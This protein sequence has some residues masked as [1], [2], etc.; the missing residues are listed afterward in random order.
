MASE[1]LRSLLGKCRTTGPIL[2]T[3]E[4]KALE[5]GSRNMC[6]NMP[7]PSFLHTQVGQACCETLGHCVLYW[8][9]H[10][11]MVSSSLSVFHCWI[12]VSLQASK[13][14]KVWH[15]TRN[16]VTHGEISTVTTQEPCP[17]ESL[18]GLF[19]SCFLSLQ[20]VL[21]TQSKL[22]NVSLSTGLDLGFDYLKLGLQLNLV[23]DLLKKIKS[24]KC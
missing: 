24:T 22:K 11:C 21:E 6:F 8:A 7:S 19:F 13:R 4:Q 17:D 18:G 1:S 15:F 16:K 20:R 23:N 14:E 12:E 3:S 2:G 10:N 9:G 5:L